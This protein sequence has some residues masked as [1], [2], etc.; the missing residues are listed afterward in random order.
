MKDLFT[1]FDAPALS[2]PVLL[3]GL[4]G[5]IDAGMAAAN[6]RKAVLEP[7]ESALVAS[8]D[9]DELLDYRARRPTISLSDGL[10][11][12]FNWEQLE[13][14]GLTS[15]HGVDFLVLAGP[16][17]DRLW[18]AFTQQVVDLAI[19][20]KVSKVIGLGAYPAAVP[21]TR[22]TKLALTTAS[23]R[24][25]DEMTGYVRG[26]LEVPAGIFAA[27]EQEFDR[28]LIDAFC[29]WAQVPHYASNLPYPAGS[30]A[31]IHGVNNLTGAGFAVSEVS[32]EAASNRVRLDE[33]IAG[34]PEHEQLVRQL[35]V[36]A[37]S[38]PAAQEVNFDDLPSG[39]Q[40]A[41]EF[42]EFLRR[43]DGDDD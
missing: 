2:S 41:E 25:S 23:P 35:E 30:L 9:T 15:P 40:L 24:L 39:D 20:F 4:D 1:R 11:T 6:A 42:Q 33:L 32:S 5:W 19:E 43:T 29:L 7:S 18:K 36:F 28:R 21:H 38:E 17:P 34:N 8:F 16:E 14:S 3:I 37:D 31:L 12:D 10:V 26:S 27:L 13:L 22:P